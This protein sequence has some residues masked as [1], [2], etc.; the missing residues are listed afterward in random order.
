V[1]FCPLVSQPEGVSDEGIS[2][3]EKRGLERSNRF[4]YSGRGYSEEHAT[5]P[6]TIGH[7]LASSPLALLA[8]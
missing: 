7:V 8:W 4:L 6:A 2:E 3:L 5:R 1:N